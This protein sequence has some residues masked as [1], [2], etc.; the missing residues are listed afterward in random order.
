MKHCGRCC[1]DRATNRQ[2]KASAGLSMVGGPALLS[3]VASVVKW[4]AGIKYEAEPRSMSRN[5][6]ECKAVRPISHEPSV[7]LQS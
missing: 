4:D 7:S 3:Q 2:N 6:R 1:C 5:G